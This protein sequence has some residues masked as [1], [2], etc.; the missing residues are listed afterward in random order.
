MPVA[1]PSLM[2]RRGVVPSF[3][4]SPLFNQENHSNLQG[5]ARGRIH[6]RGRHRRPSV[7]WEGTRLLVRVLH[8]AATLPQA[9][10]RAGSPSCSVFF[11]YGKG[12]RGKHTVPCG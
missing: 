3:S 4:R 10:G 5:K 7:N 12:T 6:Q 8:S 2:A 1:A 9:L 11:S